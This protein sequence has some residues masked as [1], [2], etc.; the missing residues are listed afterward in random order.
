[1]DLATTAPFRDRRRRV[2]EAACFAAVGCSGIAVNLGAYYVLTRGVGLPIELA[3]PPAIELSVLWNFALNDAWTF[4]RR[5]TARRLLGRIGRFHA[6]S[7]GAGVLN[8]L[9]LLVLARAGWWDIGANLIGIG[10]A[11]V[12]K[13]AINSSWTWREHEAT[14]RLTAP[15]GGVQ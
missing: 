10:V 8:Y 14:P 7:L 15:D 11:A 3:S 2:R 9:I 13:F 5:R 12:M 1:M 6:V 4:G